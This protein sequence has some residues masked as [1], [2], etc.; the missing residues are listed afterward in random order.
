MEESN[1]ELVV[2]LTDQLF[3][4]EVI[5]QPGLVLIDFYAEWCG[6]CKLM[7]PT[8]ELAAKDYD[9]KIRFYKVDTDDFERSGQL[10]QQYQI[11][12]IP[13][14]YILKIKQ[15][16]PAENG[17]SNVEVEIVEKMVGSMDGITFMDKLSEAYKAHNS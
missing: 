15:A 14:T 7:E 2:L 10:L 1:K 5:K 12:S 9:G 13:T 16:T 11:R 4:E 17:Q 3:A 6:P 8:I